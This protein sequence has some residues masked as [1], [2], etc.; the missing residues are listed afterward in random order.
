MKSFLLNSKKSMETLYYHMK[1]NK[2]IGARTQGI[3]RLQAAAL[4]LVDIVESE[5]MHK[6]ERVRNICTAEANISL[7]SNTTR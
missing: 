2:K 6:E 7:S 1:L 3:H 4:G 5:E